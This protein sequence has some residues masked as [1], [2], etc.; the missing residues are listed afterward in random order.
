MKIKVPM[1]KYIAMAYE[2]KKYD[3]KFGWEFGKVI[4]F[5]STE[6]TEPPDAMGEFNKFLLP[7]KP[8]LAY[9][10]VTENGEIVD[11]EMFDTST[12][13]NRLTFRIW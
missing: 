13:K 2:G 8:R 9:M 1:L 7:E 5:Q 4:L 10:R 6:Y 3:E 12:N 11:E